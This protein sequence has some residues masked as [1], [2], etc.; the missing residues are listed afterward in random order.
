MEFVIVL[1]LVSVMNL[2]LNVISFILVFKGENST[3]VI[4]SKKTLALACIQT[5]TDQFVKFDVMIETTKLYILRL[6]GWPWPSFKVT[7]VWEIKNFFV[8]FLLLQF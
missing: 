6:V 2:I 8:H 7:G 3:Y 5:F 4:S 1:R